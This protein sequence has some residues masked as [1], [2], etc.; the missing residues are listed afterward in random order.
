MKKF[1][2]LALAIVMICALSVTCFAAIT[3]D[4]SGSETETVT[5]TYVG[6]QTSGEVFGVDVTFGS[7]AFTYTDDI[8][9]TWNPDEHNYTGAADAA[10]S[11][12]T[13]ANKVTVTNHSNVDITVTVAYA[14]NTEDGVNTVT[15][16]FGVN[17][18]TTFDLDA[19]VEN[20][21][22]QADSYSVYLT[23]EGAIS[24]DNDNLG[25]VTVTVA[26]KAS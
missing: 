9:G 17:A 23:L 21:K 11:C 4:G 7:M 24:A 1:F 20:Q 10:W 5:A 3:S 18:T 14:D 8:Q 12:E 16:K 2:A 19:G 13:D 26:K 22:A 15:G 6:P 25:T